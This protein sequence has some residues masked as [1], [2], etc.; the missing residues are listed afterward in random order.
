MGFTAIIGIIV[1]F[2]F[3]IFSIASGGDISEFIHMGSIMIVFGGSIGALLLN[4][5]VE[6]FARALRS[7]IK[8]LTYKKNNLEDVLRKI[9]SL[10]YMSKKEGLLALETGAEDIEDPFFKK[11]VMLVV[12]GTSPEQTKEAMELE[13]SLV[14]EK[15]EEEQRF[16]L[17]AAKFFPAFGMI[18]TL[19]GLIN[20][21]QNLSDSEKLG[22]AMAVA[23]V[24]TFYGAL[25]ANVIFT[26]MAG[27]LKTMNSEDRICKEMIIRGVLAIQSGETPYLI[28]E[29]LTAFTDKK[30]K[31]GEKDL[32]EE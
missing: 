24:T 31:K 23:L 30:N 19:I 26:P 13:M 4:H 5:P 6:A 17:D 14:D 10:A 25:I 1:A 9:I 2:G 15:S 32:E 20:M 11:G 29:K 27:R 12:D 28:E 16:M 8:I 7:F 22:P 21:L 3:V 18:G